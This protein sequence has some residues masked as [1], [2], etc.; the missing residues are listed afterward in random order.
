MKVRI[1]QIGN[2]RVIR[3]PK[4]L[5]P[6][7]QVGDVVD[8]HIKPGHHPSCNGIRP[9]NGRTKAARRMRRHSED[10]LLDSHISTRFDQEDWEWE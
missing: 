1:Q 9:R 7:V 6:E 3:L 5:L 10:H 8:L 4:T 2:S